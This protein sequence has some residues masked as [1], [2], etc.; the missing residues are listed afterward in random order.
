MICSPVSV[1]IRDFVDTRGGFPVVYGELQG[2]SSRILSFYDRYDVQ[3]A[4][5]LD[6]WE[7]D[8]CAGEIRGG[9]IWARGVTDNKGN[10]SARVA[11]IDAWQQVRG[12]LQLGVKFIIEGEE[13]I[14]S[15]HLYNFA[16]DHPELC[17]ADARIWEFGGRGIDGT[18]SIQLGLK[19]ICH[20]ELR[21]KG[22][23]L[24]W[25]SSVGTSVP[26]PA[27]RLVWALRS[28]KALDEHVQIPG[29]YDQ[30]VS[31]TEAELRVLA[32][33]PNTEAA[34]LDNLG[35]EQFLGGRT[36]VELNAWDYFQPT[37]TISGIDS[38]YHGAG[39]KTVLP[40]TATAKLDMRLV[41]NQDPF[42]IYD[43]LR[44]HLDDRGF[45]DIATEPLAQ[46]YPV[47]TRLDAPIAQVVTETYRELCG[48][49]PVF[50]PTSLGS[51]PLY[52]LCAQFGIDAATS[53]AE[54]ARSQVH[55]PNE[56]IYVDDFVLAI[57][58]VCQIMERFALV[59]RI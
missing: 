31:P 16:E 59:E 3:H 14:G 7:S 51:G 41:A 15:P 39:M 37:C 6:Q 22:A 1:S 47:R 48:Q 4:D 5:P 35:I 36:G 45:M 21:A 29:F 57:K 55:A 17:R 20:V 43:L 33:M 2:V 10:I 32:E 27:W 53:G 46:Q 54:N 13:E 24:D 50:L 40:S 34:R 18:P 49:E 42:V 26:N 28:L 56:N 8:P 25:H 11:A 19:G 52:Q 30:V 9:K 23:R 58:H 44:K 38:G 12:E